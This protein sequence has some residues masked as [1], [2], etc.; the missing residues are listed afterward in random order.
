MQFYVI[1]DSLEL[2]PILTSKADGI[3]L[4]L[5]ASMF[6]GYSPVGHPIVY[7]DAQLKALCTALKQIKANGKQAGQPGEQSCAG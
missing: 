2:T 3:A 5:P 4:S 1:S 6:F 7:N